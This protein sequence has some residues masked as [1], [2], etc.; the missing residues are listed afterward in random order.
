MNPETVARARAFN[1]DRVVEVLCV[2]AVNGDGGE[3]TKVLALTWFSTG[4]RHGHFFNP[5][6]EATRG[7]YRGEERLVDVARIVRGA[8]D[9]RHLA[10]QGAAL[11]A[12]AHQ[13]QRVGK[14]CRSRWSPYH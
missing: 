7:V 11:L 1:G 6:G 12:D 9:P 10:A 13:D 5:R 4:A 2:R 8:E 14:E 3:P